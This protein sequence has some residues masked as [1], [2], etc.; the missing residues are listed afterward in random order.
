MWVRHD[1]LDQLSTLGGQ[2][3]A[4]GQ[5]TGLF[6]AYLALIQLVLMSRSPWLDQIFGMDGLDRGAPLAR[7]RD[8]LAAPRARRV[9]RHGLFPRRRQQRRRGG[10]H[11]RDDLS[12]RPD[13]GR[14]RRAVRAG[15]GHFGPCR[16]A[17]PVVRDVVRAPPL[18]VSRDRPRLP[19]PGLRRGRLHP[20]S[21]RGRLLG[22]AL[23]HRG[24]VHPRLPHRPARLAV[25]APPASRR[26]RRRGGP[27]RLLDLRHRARPRPAR[28]PVRPVLHVAVPDPRRLVAR[29]SV[30]DLVRAER[31]LA[32]DHHQGARRLV[33]GA[34]AASRSGRGSSSRA[35]TA[36]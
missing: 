30:L 33:V 24:R 19:A 10:D 21:D 28:R 11:A 9:H 15:G 14:Q 26:E 8:R 32:A 6:A 34:S 2:L 12:V 16:P 36:S 13:G 3:T 25:D 5:L 29:T 31:R 22:R 20:R 7:L 27:R 35:R 17:P 23:R 18:R 4:I 1:G